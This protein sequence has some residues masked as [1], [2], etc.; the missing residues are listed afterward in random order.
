[1]ANKVPAPDALRAFVA[2]ERGRFITEDDNRFSTAFADV[3]RYREFLEIIEARHRPLSEAL[4]AKSRAH[5]AQLRE[6]GGGRS[7]MTDADWIETAERERLIVALQLEIESFYL[8]AKILLDEIARVVEFYFGRVTKLRLISHDQLT[9]RI[10][11][12]GDSHQLRV[13]VDFTES[14]GKLKKDISDHR[15]LYIA[16]DLN[17]RVTRGIGYDDKGATRIVQ[18][19]VYPTQTDK[20]APTRPISELLGEIDAYLLALIDFIRANGAR[21]QLRVLTEEA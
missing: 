5:W 7:R 8:F 18:G 11:A 15:D 16:H 2:E 10:A 4:V 13:S 20:Y 3:H 12:Y 14:A 6:R 21:T 1:M 17:L 19:Y 9:K